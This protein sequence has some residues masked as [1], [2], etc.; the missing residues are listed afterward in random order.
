ML[1]EHRLY[2]DPRSNLLFF[3]TFET[4]SVGGAQPRNFAVERFRPCDAL[5]GDDGNCLFFEAVFIA[6]F[7]RWDTC[8]CCF[9]ESV[10]KKLVNYEDYGFH[11]ADV[12]ANFRKFVED[13]PKFKDTRFAA[14]DEC[15]D[16]I[17][18]KA[19]YIPGI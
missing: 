7:G 19:I 11:D 16:G 2:W 17:P 9:R 10:L 1:E 12:R 8:G 13:D 5:V 15:I 3:P 6:R 18:K 4:V 14:K